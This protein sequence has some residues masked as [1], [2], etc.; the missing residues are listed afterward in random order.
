VLCREV[1]FVGR[2]ELCFGSELLTFR[3]A[4]PPSYRDNIIV[5]T[6]TLYEFISLPPV[7]ANQEP[8]IGIKGYWVYIHEGPDHLNE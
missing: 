4:P 3:H 5:S 6:K 7:N 1:E 8:P 2:R